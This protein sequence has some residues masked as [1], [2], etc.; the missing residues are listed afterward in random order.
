[1]KKSKL[2]RPT[3]MPKDTTL[4]LRIADVTKQELT[5]CVEN[6]II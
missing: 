2:G 5:Y 4:R 3:D 6:S 1:M